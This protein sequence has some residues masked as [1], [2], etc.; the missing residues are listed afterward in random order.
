[1]KEGYLDDIFDILDAHCHPCILMGTFALRWMGTGVSPVLVSLSSSRALQRSDCNEYKP[2]DLLIR[3]KG[4]GTVAAAQGAGGEVSFIPTCR[5]D[6]LQP[7]PCIFERTDGT[8]PSR[9]GVKK[10]STSLLIPLRMSMSATIGP[11]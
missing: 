5:E 11:S 2:L 6:Y 7:P 9:Y 4:V 3:N 10:L 8:F 1:M